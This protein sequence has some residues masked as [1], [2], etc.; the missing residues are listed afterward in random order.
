MLRNLLYAGLGV[1]LVGATAWAGG[2]TAVLNADGTVTFTP[3]ANFN[4]TASFTY[5]VSDGTTTSPP[6]T[7]TV[8]VAPAPVNHAPVANADT[9]AATEN[10]P[11]TY[12]A[13][14][15]LD[16]DSDSDSDTLTIASV[17]SGGGSSIND[18]TLRF[19]Q[20]TKIGAGEAALV[21][22]EVN[23]V[24][25]T[26]SADFTWTV[27]SHAAV[28]APAAAL[29]AGPYVYNCS[30]NDGADTA[31][32]TIDID[33]NA[34]DVTTFAQMTAATAEQLTSANA[35]I[36]YIRP[37][38]RLAPWDNNAFAKNGNTHTGL[39]TITS[40]DFAHPGV[41]E[42]YNTGGAATTSNIY[43]RWI[44]FDHVVFD[45]SRYDRLGGFG[46]A[47]ALLR[48][49][50]AQTGPVTISNS[51]FF[52]KSFA[53]CG[54]GQN[55]YGAINSSGFTQTD[56]IVFSNNIIHDIKAGVVGPHNNH[57]SAGTFTM[58]GNHI[59]N[60]T[61]DGIKFSGDA[62][63]G[64]IVE[65]N[66]VDSPAVDAWQITLDGATGGA[67]AKQTH[68][69]ALSGSA[70][71]QKAL[72]Y[73]QITPL[74]TI[75]AGGGA[76]EVFFTNGGLTVKRIAN[77]HV[78]V[79]ALDTDGATA[80]SMESTNQLLT[81]L[82]ND[83]LVSID[84][85]GT[86]RLY[87]WTE[88]AD[89]TGAWTAAAS[90]TAAGQTLDLTGTSII[91]DPSTDSHEWKT[92]RVAFW[93]GVA[94]DITSD[95]VR[96]N[97]VQTTQS[98]TADPSWPGMMADPALSVAAYGSPI[99]DFYGDLNTIWRAGI[100]Q[101]TGGN[102]VDTGVFDRVHG[103]LM[104]N[105]PGTGFA[106]HGWQIRRNLLFSGRS[107]VLRAND[108]F[109]SHEFQGIFFEDIA[110]ANY[111]DMVIEKNLI[112]EAGSLQGVSLFNGITSSLLNNTAV[113]VPTWVPVPSSF[114]PT[115]SVDVNFTPLAPMHGNNVA[116]NVSKSN[117]ALCATAG[118]TA[119]QCSPPD[120][121]P[122]DTVVNNT[123]TTPATVGTKAYSSIFVGPFDETVDTPAEALAAFS[124]KP[125]GALAING[126]GCC[127]DGAFRP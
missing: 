13:A 78:V 65:D 99:V 47:K 117:T 111:T 109:N 70:D 57:G 87:L 93:Q 55:Y 69:G 15:L 72:F 49:S 71:G 22:A 79:T 86:S 112:V 67:N 125:G 31:V 103:D 54:P 29:G 123:D 36:Y 8:N 91:G 95:A 64:T 52:G 23:Q 50:T 98:Y 42:A 28:V 127:T 38:A 121:G 58:S 85:A 97:F 73:T 63:D 9:L 48:M 53:L 101:G 113:Q 75:G 21:G 35:I 76:D 19:G 1:V 66:I 26:G 32:V 81:E 17:T 45:G 18:Q 46:T 51:E 14:Q 114:I 94:P 108:R 56:N 92:N 80:I 77:G 4:G 107:D 44:K 68:S 84:T 74:D 11:V 119:A 25:C 10:T 105:I 12:T 20:L 39:W 116:N 41:M 110:D 30:F 96:A 90:Q 124:A 16:N 3:D 126:W 106:V 37:D 102:F 118:H 61:G 27:S 82:R 60:M 5:T 120:G 34:Y 2:G 59:Y 122:S 83:I 40:R 7:V 89:C 88:G 24:S 6:A 115:I 62:P 43:N 100:N 104:Q 33:A